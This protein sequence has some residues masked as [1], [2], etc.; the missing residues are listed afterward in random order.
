MQR[1]GCDQ[2]LVVAVDVVEHRQ[3]PGAVLVNGIG[4][5]QVLFGEV[6][7]LGEADHCAQEAIADVSG[8]VFNYSGRQENSLFAH[9]IEAV[10]KVLAQVHLGET[11][12]IGLGPHEVEAGLKN[13]VGQL[14]VTPSH[15]LPDVVRNPDSRE[16]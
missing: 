3:V 6:D 5:S 2:F 7:P 13:A 16:I 8:M 9:I 10:V 15:G 11:S 1:V 14:L 4:E 12:W